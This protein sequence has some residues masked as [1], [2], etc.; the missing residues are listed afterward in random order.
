MSELRSTSPY[1]IFVSCG[2]S[3]RI[4]CQQATV[5]SYNYIIVGATHHPTSMCRILM[6]KHILA[7]HT[8]LTVLPFRS[9]FVI[10]CPEFWRSGESGKNFPPQAAHML[11]LSGEYKWL[12]S[13]KGDGRGRDWSFS[14]EI[15]FITLAEVGLAV[16]SIACVGFRLEIIHSRTV[17]R[18]KRERELKWVSANYWHN[19]AGVENCGAWKI[20]GLPGSGRL[21]EVCLY[22]L[23][24]RYLTWRW[25]RVAT[26][27]QSS[28]LLAA[29]AVRRVIRNV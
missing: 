18:K 12:N 8:I 29:Y 15:E 17:L 23:R 14:V 6:W 25:T 7:P 19:F 24:V 10:H 11:F 3:M 4:L 26:V 21:F 27:C 9:S 2:R 1:P 22:Q 16:Q 5:A 28:S 20:N 13:V